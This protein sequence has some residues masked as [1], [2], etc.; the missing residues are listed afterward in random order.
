[1][2]IAIIGTGTVGKTLA[3]KLL[4]LDHDVMIGTRNVSEKLA[5]TAKDTYGNPPFSDWLKTNSKA[6]VVFIF[7]AVPL[8]GSFR[9]KRSLTLNLAVCHEVSSKTKIMYGQER[10]GFV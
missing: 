9:W 4:E 10:E 5:S 2:K 6:K 7:M 8:F 3:A 1:M